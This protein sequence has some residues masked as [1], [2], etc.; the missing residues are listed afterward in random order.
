MTEKCRRLAGK[1]A[2]VTG[3]GTTQAR[4]N[5]GTGQAIALLFARQGAKVLVADLDADRAELT[6]Q[7]ILAEGG[8]AAVV[9]ANVAEEA[10]CRAMVEA[11]VKEYGGVHVLVNN[12]GAGASG[13]VT[14]IGAADFD[15]A[16]DVNIKGA[17][18]A[19]KYAIPV[20]AEAG[21]GSIINITSIDGMRTGGIRNVP[22]SVA[23]AGLS[24]LSTLMACHHGHQNIRSNCIAPGHIY[25][26][27]VHNF[28]TPDIRERRRRAAPLG[29]EGNAWDVAWAAV[30]LA[31]DEAR[32]ISG[33]VLPVD[34]GLATATPLAMFDAIEG[35][36]NGARGEV[37]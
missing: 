8:E 22:Y 32:W 2:I 27:Y 31:S 17:A 1:I 6:R 36:D 4:D 20:M 19:A 12:A 28:L 5:F 37:G 21:G 30:F 10:G 35:G 11:C 7:T 15:L 9:R 16:V 13:T 24:H 3:A 26:S 29:T 34:G 18:M 25:G 33:I 23:K 14:D